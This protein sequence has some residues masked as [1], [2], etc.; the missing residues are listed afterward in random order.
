MCFNKHKALCL[1]ITE[2]VTHKLVPAKLVNS[3]SPLVG[4][5]SHVIQSRD[6]YGQTGGRLR[7]DNE[8][9]ERKSKAQRD[10]LLLNLVPHLLQGV[11]SRNDQR[12]G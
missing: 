5:Y 12:A 9:E 7:Q 10:I 8:T 3:I 4:D 1:W 11:V 2:E 6:E